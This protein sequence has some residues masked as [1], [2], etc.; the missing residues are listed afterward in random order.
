MDFSREISR[1]LLQ[2]NAIKLSPQKPFTWSSGLLSPIYC[3]NRIILSYPEIRNFVIEGF[4]EKSGEFGNFDFIG[5]V[6]TAGIPHGALLSDRLGLPFI[7]VRSKP[8]GHGRQN[9]IEGALAEGAR[10]LMVEDLISTG[11]SSLKAVEAV[12]KAGAEVVGVIAIFGYGFKRA[13][14]AFAEANCS[15]G[16]LSDYDTLLTI[17]AEEQRISLEERNTLQEWSKAPEEWSKK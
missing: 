3:D 4:V 8:K 5:G 7:Y 13:T 10:V 17:A 9:Q 12:R 2:I 14:A 1:K 6:A 11:G 16:T 15:F